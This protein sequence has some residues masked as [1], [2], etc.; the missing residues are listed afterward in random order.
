M[1]RI[2]SGLTSEAWWA[3]IVQKLFLAE[4]VAKKT[5]PPS[6]SFIS[7]AS[8]HLYAEFATHKHWRKL[9]NCDLVLTN[10]KQKAYKLGVVSN[11]DNRLSSILDEMKLAHYFD[12][13]VMPGNAGGHYKP[14]QDVFFEAMRR[15]HLPE[16]P[17]RIVHVGDDVELDYKAAR[18]VQINAILIRPSNDTTIT[19]ANGNDVSNQHVIGDL[20]KLLDIF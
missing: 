3:E 9:D 13:V 12:F 7:S 2:T 1:I 19:K 11:F 17:A 4:S 16:Q 14:Q 20:K 10:L 15:A 5:P 8:D 6:E 18:A